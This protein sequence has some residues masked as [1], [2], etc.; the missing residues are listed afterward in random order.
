MEAP[1][2]IV[3]VLYT[4]SLVIGVSEH[5][6]PREDTNVWINIIGIIIMISLLTWGGFFR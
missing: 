3:I 5:G 1:Q 4:A 2:I 6:N